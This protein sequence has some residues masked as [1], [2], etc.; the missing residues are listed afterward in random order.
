M[1]WRMKW[2]PT[3]A[4]LPGKSHE[5]Q[6]L[7]VYSPWGCKES[8][9]T[10][11][12]HIHMVYLSTQLSNL[13]KSVLMLTICQSQS[14]A[15]KKKISQFPESGFLKPPDICSLLDSSLKPILNKKQRERFVKTL[16]SP[17]CVMYSQIPGIMDGHF[18]GLLF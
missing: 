1:P 3:P 5:Q 12:A 10:E 2:Q 4:F 13:S 8:N 18:S 17:S 6:S 14:S 16:I 9:T 11:H 15:E 7:A